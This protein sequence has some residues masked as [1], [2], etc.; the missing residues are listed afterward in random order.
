MVVYID[1]SVIVAAIDKGDRRNK[2]AEKFLL[3]ERENV[4]YPRMYSF[5]HL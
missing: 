5:L 3:R 2:D 4:R 1:T